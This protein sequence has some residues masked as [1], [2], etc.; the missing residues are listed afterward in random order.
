MKYMIY[1][2]GEGQKLEYFS[3]DR[4]ELDGILSQRGETYEP[5]GLYICRDRIGSGTTVYTAMRNLDGSGTTEEFCGLCG[6]VH[7]LHGK[8]VLARSFYR[9]HEK[10]DTEEFADWVEDHQV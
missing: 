1:N 6:A 7:W 10:T 3:L 4:Q 8:K 2:K 5:R 9:E